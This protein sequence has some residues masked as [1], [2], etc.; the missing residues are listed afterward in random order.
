MKDLYT[1]LTEEGGGVMATPGN[2]MGM[3]DPQL[4]SEG[5]TGSEPLVQKKEGVPRKKV[6]KKTAGKACR[7]S[8]EEE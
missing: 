2:T 5:N 6:R 3:G 4:P 1:Y 7:K 8:S